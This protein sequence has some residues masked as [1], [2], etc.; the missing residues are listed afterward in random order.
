[1]L[2]AFTLVIRGRMLAAAIACAVIEV[3][4]RELGDSIMQMQVELGR[5][6]TTSDEDDNG[7]TGFPWMTAGA[8]K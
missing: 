2:I 4:S 3:V 6:S 1:M 7:R 8:C 5:D